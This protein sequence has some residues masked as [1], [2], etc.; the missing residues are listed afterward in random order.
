MARILVVD[1]ERNIRMMVRLALMHSGHEVGVATDGEEGLA[2]FGSG[3]DWDLVLL[4]QRMPGMEG[5]EVLREIQRRSPGARVIMITAFGTIDLAVDAMKSG[6]RDFLR[7]PFTAEILRGAVESGLHALPQEAKTPAEQSPLTFCLSTIN[8]YWIES[9]PGPGERSPAGLVHAFTVTGPSR[10]SRTIRVT[11]PSFVME[12]IRAHADRENMPGGD[13]FWQAL[14]EEAV[15][16]YLWQNS[17]FPPEEALR[18][19]DMTPGLQRWI[20]AV[21]APTR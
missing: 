14:C 21:L 1:D 9:T 17:C 11:L 4:D 5:L 16:N 13:R 18:I 7:K 15:A 19:D 2:M 10:D 3:W 6:A 8:G 20:D 12:L